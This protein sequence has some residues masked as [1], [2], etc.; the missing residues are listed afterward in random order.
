[1]FL[2][3]FNYT[4]DALAKRIRAETRPSVLESWFDDA[5]M[6]ADEQALHGMVD[7]IKQ[8]PLAPIT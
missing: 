2:R 5:L 7:R 3:R 6:L 4:D 1:M 8:T